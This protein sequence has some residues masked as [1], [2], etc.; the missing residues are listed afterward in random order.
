[1]NALF[2][3]GTVAYL[4]LLWRW[5]RMATALVCSGLGWLAYQEALHGSAAGCLC[6]L[7]FIALFASL[8]VALEGSPSPQREA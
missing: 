2:L 6:I 3:S 4:A 5:P 1:V 7:A 8:P